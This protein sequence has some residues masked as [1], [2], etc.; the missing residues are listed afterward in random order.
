MM[1]E[2]MREELDKKLCAK[3]PK[4]FSQRNLPMTETCMCWGFDCGDG[5]YWIIDNLCHSIQEYVDSRNEGIRLR[6]LK[7]WVNGKAEEVEWQVE[8]VQVKEK[9]GGLRF[10]INHGDDYIY[11]MIWLA[12]V[13]SKTTCELCGTHVDVSSTEGNWIK[14]LCPKCKTKREK[15]RRVYET[16]K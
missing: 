10:Y 13:M 15:E 12:E 14:Y 9:W 8:A 3:Y 7:M 5:W 6:K 2:K 1:E 16:K 11:G 4:I